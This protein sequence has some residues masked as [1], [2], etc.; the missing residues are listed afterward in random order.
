MELVAN[1]S[2]KDITDLR[3]RRVGTCSLNSL[4]YILVALMAAYIGLDPSKDIDWVI[5]EGSRIDGFFEGRYDALLF[6]P[7]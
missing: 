3:G 6:T 5:W 7:P 1:D 2:V 4:G